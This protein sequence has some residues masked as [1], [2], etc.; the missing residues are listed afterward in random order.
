[1]SKTG[2]LNLSAVCLAACL[3][4][5]G[6]RVLA[7]ECDQMPNHPEWIFC[8]DFEVADADNF[9]NYW[10]D[11]YGAPERMF[12]INENPAGVEGTRSV[13]M[14]IVND[15]DQDFT[16]AQP[17]EGEARAATHTIPPAARAGTAA[18]DEPQIPCGA[19]P[20][21]TFEPSHEESHTDRQ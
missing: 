17:G 18:R 10:N 9:S 4:L 14:Q 19:D 15:T 12:L 3:L 8:H 11:I 20:A 13:R 21:R 7:A 6:N 1:M 2:R 5:S 16:S